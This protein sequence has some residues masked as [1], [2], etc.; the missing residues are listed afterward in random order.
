[1]LT[2]AHR[3]DMTCGL[4]LP[5]Q[6]LV[7]HPRQTLPARILGQDDPVDIHEAVKAIE[8]PAEVL[9]VVSRVLIESQQK[10][11]SPRPTPLA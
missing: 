10:P 11:R 8:K 4:R 9:I 1:M 7:H 2:L 3:A 5:E 6:I